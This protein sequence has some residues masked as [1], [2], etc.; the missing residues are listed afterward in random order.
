VTNETHTTVIWARPEQA[1]FLRAV[2]DSAGLAVVGAGSPVR[3]QSGTVAGA[4]GVAAVDDL[5]ALLAE[6]DAKLVLIGAVEDFGGRPEDARAVSAAR[7]RGVKIASMEPVPASALELTEAG[8][9]SAT[10]VEA[11]RFVGLPRT[12]R[13][14][15]E[16]AESLAAFGAAR[17][18]LIESWGGP[19]HGSLGARLFWA[20][21][22]ALQLLGEPEAIDAAYQGAGVAGPPAMNLTQLHGDI[23][24]KL[25]GGDGRIALIAASDQA[26]RWNSSA[27]LLSGL[28]RLRFYDD[29]FEWIG[30]DGQKR[31]ELR[32]G[33]RRAAPV[34]DHAVRAIA[35]S[36]TRLLDPAVPEPA[37]VDVGAVLRVAQAALLS[38]RTGQPESPGTIKRMLAVGDAV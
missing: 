28:G 4:F 6:T 33:S 19:E 34:V 2:A 14:F 27:T 31:D 5:R 12:G 25:R 13:P 24:A 22:L 9:N 32:I 30:P 8:W 37:P 10:N 38:A 11:V 20:L 16:A 26:G 29:G 17:T 3:A 23:T 36:I 18:M 21:E 1:G 7:G 35:D 15:R